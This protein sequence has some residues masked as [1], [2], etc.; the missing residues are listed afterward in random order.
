MKKYLN[1][2]LIASAMGVC[3][4]NA[5][6]DCVGISRSVALEVTADRSQVLEIVSKY[7]S[8]APGCVC[9]V[10]KSAI[11]ASEADSGRVAAIVEVAVTA[12]PDQIPLIA[13]CAIATAPDAVGD[14]QAVLV[15]L[16]DP[17]LRY[18][19]VRKGFCA[20]GGGEGSGF[21]TPWNPLDF[22]G[23]GNPDV[24]PLPGMDGGNIIL[25][26]GPQYEVAP[27]IQPPVVPPVVTPVN[28]NA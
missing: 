12:N 15:R 4:V 16:L 11:N 3:G 9:E 1:S 23:N 14:I 18:N 5:E 21:N 10:V 26:P 17:I 28:P 20:V 2:A 22:P 7:A 24:G 13:N 27:I 19:I 6:V 25:R 8:E